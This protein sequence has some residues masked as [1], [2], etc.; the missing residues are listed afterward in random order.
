M[1]MTIS[2]LARSAGVNV[3]TI[4]YYQRRGL[5]DTPLRGA[6]VRR[7]GAADAR[8]LGFIRSA[9]A[10]GFTLEQIDELLRLDAGQDRARAR[11]LA[12]ERIAALDVKIAEL[13]GARA[14]LARLARQCDASE[15][16]PCPIIAAF[17]G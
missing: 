6:G 12:A 10:A 17:E 2:G 3:E 4:R 11:E 13:A 9:Q 15:G 16:G 8:R 14:A 7:Y 1:D 5:L